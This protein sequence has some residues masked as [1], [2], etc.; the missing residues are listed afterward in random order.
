MRCTAEME[1]MNLQNLWFQQN[2]APFHTSHQL[3]DILPPKF[4]NYVSS[5]GP[6]I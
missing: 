6:A 3:I 4:E 1:D 2:D 5:R